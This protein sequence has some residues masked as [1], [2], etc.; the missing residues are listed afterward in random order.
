MTLYHL[1]PLFSI[2]VGETPAIFGIEN[3]FDYR[4]LEPHQPFQ[5]CAWFDWS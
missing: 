5:H 3:D 2:F 4:W 1:L